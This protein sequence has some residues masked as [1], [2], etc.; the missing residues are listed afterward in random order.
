MTMI[1]DLKLS[2]LAT[3]IDY[4][5]QCM[6]AKARVFLTKNALCD[7]AALRVG[8]ADR[9]LGKQLPAPRLKAGREIRA[10]LKQAGIL[11]PNGREVFRGH[12]TVPLTDAG[13]ETTGIYGLRLDVLTG[14]QPITIIGSGLFNAAAL[15]A[16]DELIVCS[17]VLDAWTLNAAG[18]HNAVVGE[19]LKK[20][21]LDRVNRVLL[22]GE[23]APEVFE[24][25]EILRI[26]FPEGFSVNRFAQAWRSDANA[27]D[28]RIRAATWI[29]GSQ[30]QASANDAAKE[31]VTINDTKEHE[32]KAAPAASPVPSAVDELEAERSDGEVKIT[33]ENRHWRIRGLDRNTTIGVMKV[34]V[35]VLNDRND[36]FHVDTLD[37]CHARSR[38]V[39]LKDCA[40]EIA[41]GEHE[42]RSDLSRILLK[43]DQLQHEQRGKDKQETKQVELTDTER[44]EALELLKDEKLL[45]RI[46]DDFET[47]GI[48]GEHAGKLAGYLSATSRLLDKP[49]GLVIQSSSAAGKSALADSVLRFM[50]PEERFSCSAMTSQSLYYLGK[51]NLRHKILSVAEQEG[52]RDAAYQLKLL[53][54][55]G[56]LSLVATSKESGSGRTSTERYEVEGPVALILT[57]TSLKVDP[58]LLNRCLVIAIDESVVQTEAI[59]Q[60]QRF[61]ET[62][63]GWFQ[64]EQAEEIVKRHQNAQRLLR[65]LP[66]FNPYAEQL[67]F[68]GSQTRHR[69]DHKKYLS[70]IKAVTL[71]HQY[72]SETKRITLAGQTVEYLEVTRQDIAKA[73]TIADWALGRSIDEL[74]G[75]TRRLLI[76]LYDWIRD[77]ADDRGIAPEEVL[78]MRREAREALGW[79]ATQ[80]NY[81]LEQLCRYEYAVRCSGGNGKLC[82]YSL[83]YDGRGREGQAALIGLVDAASL[84]DPKTAPTKADLSD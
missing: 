21:H 38:R 1:D 68:I 80:L 65:R 44:S 72:Q 11:K 47:C 61:A 69:R 2:P 56:R 81:H 78:F 14:Q 83:L 20:E 55:E 15:A 30:P 9:T 75:P 52:V 73:N 59:L 12:V 50:P 39:F 10:Q 7:D 41:A 5:A 33:I 82:R 77:Q 51:E 42:L 63:E 32:V 74:S 29:A 3:T 25:K 19:Q 43:L 40:E 49:L 36:R 8:F 4:Y 16:F 35:I 62:I 67:G 54:S 66:V 76:Q 58:E 46:L 57:T 53:Q 45:D 22:A 24:G 34:N 37:L 71:L 79:N 84:V 64:Q 18:Y 27:F 17:D 70:L 28:K 6:S 31:E 26:N 60:Q 48:V 13:G 23:I